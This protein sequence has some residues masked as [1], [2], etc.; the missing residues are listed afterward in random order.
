MRSCGEK[1]QTKEATL[2]NL[3][4]CVIEPWLSSDGLSKY[5][6]LPMFWQ[7]V[8]RDGE[9]CSLQQAHPSLRDGHES[10]GKCLSPGLLCLPTL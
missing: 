9:L 7:V 4:H 2:C 6:I 1:I 5:S 10:Q 3:L 8:W